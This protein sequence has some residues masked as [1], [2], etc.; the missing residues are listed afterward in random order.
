MSKTNISGKITRILFEG[1]NKVGL[2]VMLPN[3]KE[4]TVL[5]PAMM[6]LE[7]GREISAQATVHVDPKWGTQYN[8]EL[9]TENIQKDPK[10]IASYLAYHAKGI[11]EVTAKKI[12]DKF[13]SSTIDV[14]SFTPENL[15]EAGISAKQVESL[16]QALSGN[17]IIQNLWNYLKPHDIGPSVIQKIYEAHKSESLNI[18]RAN[19]YSLCDLR[20]ISFK[21]ADR[22][23]LANNI[24]LDSPERME[25]A[26]RFVIDDCINQKGDTAIKV[27]DLIKGIS[28]LTQVS[29]QDVIQRTLSSLTKKGE[30]KERVINDEK[31]FS[32]P[33]YEMMEKFIASKISMLV[34]IPAANDILKKKAVENLREITP[35]D[36]ELNPEQK[37]AVEGAF[38]HNLMIITG[39]PGCGK[40][41]ISQCIIKAAKQEKKKILIC[42]PTGKAA[43]RIS[44][45]TGMP[46]E[47]IHGILV[48]RSD[49]GDEK[50]WSFTHNETN[51]ID[52]DYLFVDE[53]SMSDTYI[54]YSLM[55]A[56][57]PRTKVIIIGD[58]D[59]I[60]SVGAGDVLR[61][62]IRSKRVPCVKLKTVQRTAKDSDIP[63]IANK[64]ITG[65][66]RKIDFDEAVNVKF[67]DVETESE[68]I[69][70]IK[71]RYS[72]D[73]QMHGI[74]EVQV[75]A[76]RVG[77]SLGVVELNK[78][79]RDIA[80][81]LK[82]TTKVLKTPSGDF[83]EGDR[84]IRNCPDKDNDVANGEIGEIES[85]SPDACV[86]NFGKKK[87][88]Y[89]KQEMSTSVDLAYAITKHKSQGSEYKS[90]VQ[91]VPS[92]HTYMLNRNLIYTAMTR[93]KSEVC[94]IGSKR[95]FHIGCSKLGSNRLTGLSMEIQKVCNKIYESELEEA[96]KEET[97][98]TKAKRKMVA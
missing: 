54:T 94:F 34:S 53:M 22:V 59:Q 12:V 50:G 67:V 18:V 27:E 81:P 89:K 58:A 42:S 86:I 5:G 43:Q 51:P 30:I 84:V 46:A 56:I 9:I 96:S 87:V 41:T 32:S 82:R 63:V 80:N 52:A 7:I 93:G 28:D 48:P 23:A 24:K 38:D 1:D 71:K 17:T 2:K 8:A 97:V 88:S 13:G 95:T 75:L 64:I 10:G 21:T 79:L 20:G 92:S 44:E 90:V 4:V 77:T 68:T 40:T 25:A 62:L 85:I 31:C 66:S 11:G 91:V 69:A 15:I 83:R 33:Y 57:S 73:I 55:R 6:D 14:I 61:E 3:R 16:K 37:Q 70:A 60:A 35:K 78:I 26:A 74:K 45:V 98:K 19:P 36:R 65:N 39:G 72:E 49:P 76:A 47:T 29:D